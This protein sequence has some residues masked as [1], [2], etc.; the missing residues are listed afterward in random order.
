MLVASVLDNTPAFVAPKAF[1]HQETPTQL[2]KA[3]GFHPHLSLLVWRCRVMEFE[4]P[5]VGQ[6][7]NESVR[8]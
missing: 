5:K 8:G 7:P 6:L 2:G 1:S 3:C 4:F